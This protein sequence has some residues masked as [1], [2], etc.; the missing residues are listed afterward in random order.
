MLNPGEETLV[1]LPALNSPQIYEI[2]CH[3]HVAAPARDAGGGAGAPSD[4]G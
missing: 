4:E 2:E 3:L 1:E